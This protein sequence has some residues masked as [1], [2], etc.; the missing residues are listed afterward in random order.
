MK[1]TEAKKIA[2]KALMD[3]LRASGYRLE[4]HDYTEEETELIE[5][6]MFQYG[7]AMAKRI[8]EEFWFG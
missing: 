3:S 6:Y 2:K 8:G 5:K 7:E 1:V 4:G